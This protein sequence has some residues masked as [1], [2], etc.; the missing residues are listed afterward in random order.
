ML[1]YALRFPAHW[2]GTVAGQ[3]GYTL[4][5]GTT[6][7][8]RT[9]STR[10]RLARSIQPYLSYASRCEVIKTH[11]ET[12]GWRI[13][14]YASV[15]V[16]SAVFRVDSETSLANIFSSLSVFLVHSPIFLVHSQIFRIPC[17]VVRIH[18]QRSLFTV[19]Y[20]RVAQPG[21]ECAA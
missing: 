20:S 8:E 4:P 9:R 12:L 17:S 18:S 21:S 10:D 1:I 14:C 3:I 15:L 2:E 6:L 19:Q 7:L 13:C 16:H 5:F 11:R